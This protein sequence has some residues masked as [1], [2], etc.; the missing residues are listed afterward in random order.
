MSRRMVS[1]S[2]LLVAAICLLATTQVLAVS[3][4]GSE[5]L[6]PAQIQNLVANWSQTDVEPQEVLPF[7]NPKYA[8]LYPDSDLLKPAVVNFN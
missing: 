2:V 5:A 3:G 4:S 6:D 1:F 8:A 7:F